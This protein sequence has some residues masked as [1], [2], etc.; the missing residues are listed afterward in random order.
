MV[1]MGLSYEILYTIDSKN[2]V[3]LPLFPAFRI[4]LQEQCAGFYRGYDAAVI[5]S[6]E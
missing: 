3:W 2:W 1:L 6:Q 4:E 5:R